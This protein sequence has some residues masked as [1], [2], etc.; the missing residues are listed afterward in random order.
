MRLARTT[1]ALMRQIRICHAAGGDCAPFALDLL[2]NQIAAELARRN[3]IEAWRV[4][5]KRSA[6]SRGLRLARCCK[7]LREYLKIHAD[8]TG[9]NANG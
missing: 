6:V 4:Y 1:L 2:G 5:S 9:V 8:L 3:T 7:V